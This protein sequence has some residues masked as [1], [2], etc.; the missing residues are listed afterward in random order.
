MFHKPF[1]DG[2]EPFDRLLAFRDDK[3]VQKRDPKEIRRIM[4]DDPAPVLMIWFVCNSQSNALKQDVTNLVAANVVIL[5][6]DA[7]IFF[8]VSPS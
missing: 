3:D 7:D 1:R 5:R 2:C 8:I 4:K 6:Y